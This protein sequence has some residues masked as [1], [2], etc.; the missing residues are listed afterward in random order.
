VRRAAIGTL[1]AAGL[2]SCACGGRDVALP[3]GVP[4]VL[5]SID[6]LRAD[7]LPAYGYRGGSTPHLD[8]LAR[9]GV[10]F[11]DAYSH[12]PLTLPSHAS[13]L[14]GLLPPHHGVRDN[15]GFTLKG[16]HQTLATRLK[17]AG[18]RT[19]GAIS[20]YVLRSQTGINQGFDFFDDALEIEGGTENL[21]AL[22]RDGAVAVDALSR[23]LDGQAGAPVFAFLHLYEPHS[24]YAPPERY[25]HLAT[26]YDG[27]I[28]YAD[29]LVGRFLDHLKATGLYDRAV[30]VVTSDHGEGLK[31]H[32]EE[33]HGVFLY[34]EAVHVPLILRLPGGA[35]GGR[36]VAG[37]VS[38]V[39][40]PATLLD[41]AG[42]VA[43]GLDGVSLRPVLNGA[44]TAAR[45]AYAETLYARYHFGWSDL[46]AATEARYRYIRAPRRE[47]YDRIKDPG[48]HE[49]L[50]EP[51]AATAAA[52][53][54]WLTS[55]G[56]GSVTPPE[57]VSAETREKLQALGYIGSGTLVA[58]DGALPD[59]K[60]KIATYEDLRQ[61]LQL[62]QEGK[63]VE[64]VAQFRKV[65]AENPK[66]MDAW[67]V[68]GVTLV[69]LGRDKEGI[70]ALE[71]AL[72]I[73]PGR[74]QTH[75]ALVKTY[76]LENKLDLAM[77]HAEIAAGTNPAEGYELLAQLMLDLKQPERAAE[78][79]RRSL[80]ADRERMM[81]HFVL[82][83]AAQRGGRY[84][85]ALASFRE[86]ERLK[87]RVHHAVVRSL[88]SNMADCLARLGR[89]AE[90]EQEFR[91]EIEAIPS[92]HEGRVGLAMLY[93][94]QSRDAE[95]RDVLGGLVAAQPRPSADSYWTV[96][97]TFRV[98]GDVEAAQQWLVRARAEFPADS[99]FR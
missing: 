88:H 63:A 35:R 87:E 22:Q 17:A 80:A 23:W 93:R 66:M 91:A 97:H 49:N 98:L 95:A 40:L 38:E 41:L 31:D 18:Y 62:R 85:E 25:A 90:A 96:V 36:R 15:I 3:R 68:L 19:G 29:E 21:S 45:P 30:L 39:D 86:A 32:G 52:M 57:E 10:L 73:D 24:P 7:H 76:V 53:D 34:R 6:T 67:E 94:S 51:R 28:A 26:A 43:P 92:S 77:K 70:A 54:G 74:P 79:A 14:T 47:L 2:A 37:V 61:A 9:E 75:I 71:Q 27:D 42:L 59:P 78:F 16:A 4:V 8:A 1:L 13:M 46:Y 5:I 81:S 84:A 33:E 99:R 12:C 83:V 72:K 69:G 89:E 58:P 11:E 56:I 64:A 20:A 44:A 55:V 48:E 65:L 50:A 82:G 60:D